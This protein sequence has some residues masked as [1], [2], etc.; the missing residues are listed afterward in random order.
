VPPPP[1]TAHPNPLPSGQ[2]DFRDSP[3]GARWREDVRAFIRDHLPPPTDRAGDSAA[4]DRWRDALAAR[5]WMA[6]AWPKAFGGAGLGVG[7]QFILNEELAESE[8]P[9]L[10]GRVAGQSDLGI[11]LGPTIITHG[12]EEQRRTHLPAI[13]RGEVWC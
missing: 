2:M 12:T 1:C 9:P 4:V 3:D 13:L 8:A 10:G 11:M 7:E 5:G 6:P